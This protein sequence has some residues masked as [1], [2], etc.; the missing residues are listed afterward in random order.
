MRLK[1]K[2]HA[3]LE[4]FRQGRGSPTSARPSSEPPLEGEDEL[5]TLGGMTRL[6]KKEGTSNP[7]SPSAFVA[8]SVVPLNWSPR[9]PVDSVHPNVRDYLG[10]FPTQQP[11]ADY[12]AGVAFPSPGYDPAQ[13]QM[14]TEPRAS[15]SRSTLVSEQQSPT[16]HYQY[17]QNMQ[18][19][20]N[21]FPA[22][23]P[24]YDYSSQQQSWHDTNGTYNALMGRDTNMGANP[25][26]PNMQN[27]WSDFVS[28]FQT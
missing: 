27:T 3:S 4:A 15:S 25:D 18:A 14:R 11:N 17:P 16:H 9:M 8:N 7:S 20:P 10:Q 12:G 2:A 1:D 24:V 21:P 23:F 13:V 26:E 28:D 6:V 22:Y 5:T 19:N